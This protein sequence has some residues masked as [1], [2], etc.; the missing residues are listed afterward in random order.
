VTAVSDAEPFQIKYRPQR[1]AQVIADQLAATGEL[2]PRRQ[3]R[4]RGMG[5]L[6][7]PIPSPG[8]DFSLSCHS[9]DPNVAEGEPTNGGVPKP[10]AAWGDEGRRRG[11]SPRSRQAVPG[12]A[13]RKSPS[14]RGAAQ[15]EGE[16]HDLLPADAHPY[17]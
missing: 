10:P 6:S 13:S 16:V 11:Q 8:R 14:V 7:G 5:S 1:T 17:E 2:A 3:D 4:G 15:P 12:H 9:A